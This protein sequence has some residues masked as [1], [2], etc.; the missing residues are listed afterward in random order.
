M[1]L[2]VGDIIYYQRCLPRTYWPFCFIFTID[3]Q[4]LP[5]YTQKCGIRKGFFRDVCSFTKYRVFNS[6]QNLINFL[7]YGKSVL[8]PIVPS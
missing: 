8:Q 1:T 6:Q 7:L 5:R 3:G 2:V 4:L